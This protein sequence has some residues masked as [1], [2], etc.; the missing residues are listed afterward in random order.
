MQLDGF[1]CV[2]SGICTGCFICFTLFHFLFRS[3]SDFL[4]SWICSVQ[5]D[6]AS[7]KNT[8]AYYSKCIFSVEQSR[9]QLIG[10]L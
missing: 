4:S 8:L 5:L 1:F 2:Q 10:C 6:G 9:K 7:I 3:V